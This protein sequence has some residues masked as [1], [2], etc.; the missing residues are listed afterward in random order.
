MVERARRS[1]GATIAAAHAALD[2][3]IAANLA[4]GTP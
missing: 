2:D 1:V 3:G 4:G